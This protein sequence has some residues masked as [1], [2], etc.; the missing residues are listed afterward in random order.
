[1]LQSG[2]IAIASTTY[3]PGIAVAQTA[4]TPATAAKATPDAHT[5]Y[6]L[7]FSS[8]NRRSQAIDGGR[9]ANP[10]AASVADAVLAAEL[11][12]SVA[13]LPAFN[14]AVADASQ[15]LDAITS[16]AQGIYQAAG[17]TNSKVT[18]AQV[19]DLNIRRYRTVILGIISVKAAISASS[20]TNVRAYVNSTFRKQT[21]VI[22]Q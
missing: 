8:H 21:Q 3:C 9:A 13:E 16:Q 15:K 14:K 11:G 2:L 6:H 17:N 4:S 10:Q 7:F 12:I 22:H 19:Q 18:I 20:W 5:L 1:M